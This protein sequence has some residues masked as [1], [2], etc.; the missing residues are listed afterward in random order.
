MELRSTRMKIQLIHP[1]AD[2]NYH[3]PEARWLRSAPIGLELIASALSSDVEVEIIDGSNLSI[4][5]ILDKIDGDYV[6][7]SDWYSKHDSALKILERAK[8][9][10]AITIIGGSNATHLS[11]RIL[12]NH[13]F[14]DYAIVG[15]G[16]EAF[17]RLIDEDAVDEISNLVYR[18]GNRIVRNPTMNVRLNRLFNLEHMINPDYD[19]NN[20]FPLSSIRGCIKAEKDERCS[21]CS[22]DHR[23]KIMNANHVWEQIGLLKSQYE[24]DYFFETGDSFIVGKYP[25]LLLDRRPEHLKNVKF[26]IYASPDQIN[27]QVIETLKK[28]NV[29]EIFLGVESVDETILRQAGKKYSRAQIDLA[30]ELIHQAG[31]QVQ[32]PFIYGLPGETIE[33][34]EKSYQYAKSILETQPHTKLLV[35]APIPLVGS[36]LFENLREDSRV[37]REYAGDLD[38]D[39]AFD[40]EQLIRLQTKYSS[41]VKYEEM[42]Q[43]VAKTRALARDGNVAGLGF[44]TINNS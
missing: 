23:L 27:E 34:M 18:Q 9:K 38:K 13:S 43:Y 35:S 16:E 3:C 4:D 24:F 8:E 22:I 28:L 2:K 25:E 1:P 12:R 37:K 40:Y 33:T 14:V 31:I 10:G 21:F 41:S 5:E 44:L 11:D 17:S 39:D 36:R 15:D 29:Q 7:V 19:R 6:G 32:V 30:L 20:P 26:R 42:M